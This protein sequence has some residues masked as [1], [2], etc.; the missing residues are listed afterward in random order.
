[1]KKLVLGVIAGV[2]GIMLGGGVSWF[3]LT[4]YDIA[5]KF[6]VTETFLVGAITA[7][8]LLVALVIGGYQL[9]A[10]RKERAANIVTA[11]YEYWHSPMVL[12]G[13]VSLLRLINKGGNLAKSMTYYATNYPEERAKLISVVNF[14]E[15]AGWLVR[16]KCISISSL[17]ALIPVESAYT[18][19]EE[20]IRQAQKKKPS[21]KLDDK[22]TILYGNFV[23]LAREVKR[24]RH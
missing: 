12:E 24:G 13:R 11:L 16:E 10:L 4:R 19:W 7:A 9:Q 1:M 2:I 21:E 5:W 22:K 3:L 20:F 17:I 14:F 23:W 18:R 6:I 8:I 15:L